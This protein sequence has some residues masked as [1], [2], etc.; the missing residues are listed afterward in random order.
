ML[1]NHFH[2]HKHLKSN[3]DRFIGV[4]LNE[5]LLSVRHLKSNMDRFIDLKLQTV[6]MLYIFKIQY[7]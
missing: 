5:L 1:H 4:T 7:G 6:L 3:M 2:N